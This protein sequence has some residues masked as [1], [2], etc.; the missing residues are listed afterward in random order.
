MSKSLNEFIEQSEALIEGSQ[1]FKLNDNEV[2]LAIATPIKG[3][4]AKQYGNM[5]AWDSGDIHMSLSKRFLD[6]DGQF[7]YIINPLKE[8]GVYLSRKFDSESDLGI[9]TELI[10]SIDNDTSNLEEL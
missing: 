5:A 8:K 10:V 7:V 9:L 3:V 6:D 1:H 2:R 4:I